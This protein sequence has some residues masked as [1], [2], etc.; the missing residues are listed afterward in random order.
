MAGCPEGQVKNAAGECVNKEDRPEKN[1]DT[2]IKGN[3]RIYANQDIITQVKDGKVNINT[4]DGAYRGKER[5]VD[6]D[7]TGMEVS[8]GW[9]NDNDD[10]LRLVDGKIVKQ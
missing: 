3:E 10:D 4:E 7:T 2:T 6:I 1:F 5:T 8:N 9:I